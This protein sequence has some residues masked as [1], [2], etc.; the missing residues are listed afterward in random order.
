MDFQAAQAYAKDEAERFAESQLLD[1]IEENLPDVED[2]EQ[3][4]E[5]N[6]QALAKFVNARW[7]LN[8]RDRDLKREGRDGV[9]ELIIDR[10]REAVSRVD[11]SDGASSWKKISA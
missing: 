1:A 3:N 10:A 9:A 7:G 8:F 5:W 6:W 2:A 11:L 4:G